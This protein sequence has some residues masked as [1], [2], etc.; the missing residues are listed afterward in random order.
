MILAGSDDESL[1]PL[2]SSFQPAACPVVTPKRTA[3]VR[4]PFRLRGNDAGEV[5][6][7]LAGDVPGRILGGSV[8]EHHEVGVRTG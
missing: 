7:N 6:S 8:D 5:R 4:D 2:R 1:F 3:R